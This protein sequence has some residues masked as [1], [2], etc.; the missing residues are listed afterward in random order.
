MTAR[1]PPEEHKPSGRPTKYAGEETD[2][3]AYNYAFMGATDKQIA[4]FLEI[5]EATVNRWK[6][7]HPTFCES[8]KKGKAE[9]DLKAI[10]SLYKRALG[11]EQPEDKIFQYEGKPV[12]VPTMRHIPADVTALIF[13]LK[14]RMPEEFRDKQ[15]IEQS[16]GFNIVFDEQDR[17]LVGAE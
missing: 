9:A 17:G 7:K 4:V 8:L 5:D 14:N 10:K 16:G 11:Y 12:V 6:E 2:K 1:K 13:W 3:L 15:Q